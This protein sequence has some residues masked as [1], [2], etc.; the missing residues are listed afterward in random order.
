MNNF[1]RIIFEHSGS[2]ILNNE[3]T[4]TEFP[5]AM[6]YPATADLVVDTL[7]D[8]FVFNASRLPQQNNHFFLQVNPNHF[9]IKIQKNERGRVLKVIHAS[10]HFIF[11]KRYVVEI[12]EGESISFFTTYS[13]KE[14]KFAVDLGVKIDN[15]NVTLK[16][17]KILLKSDGLSFAFDPLSNNVVWHKKYFKDG[18]PLPFIFLQCLKNKE[19]DKAR[20]ML[21]F[22]ID[23]QGLRGYFGEFDILLNNYLGD[24]N[25][26]SIVQGGVVKNLRFEVKDGLIHNVE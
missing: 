24:E 12:G 16:D 4:I 8:K 14:N 11:P 5:F 22:N 20:K 13:N 19:F 2:L 1:V 3:L 25:I 9:I 6:D 10:T 17:N 18:S 21:A 23:E 7:D 15:P 26:F